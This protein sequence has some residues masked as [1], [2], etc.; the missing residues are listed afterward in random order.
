[1]AGIGVT[2]E[3]HAHM[4][5]LAFFRPLSF[6]RN[7]ARGGRRGAGDRRLGNVDLGRGAKGPSKMEGMQM[8]CTLPSTA[9]RLVSNTMSET[10]SAMKLCGGE[11]AERRA[12]L[13]GEEELEQ[14]SNACRMIV[15]IS[16]VWHG[17]R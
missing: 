4:H 13:R 8:P 14:A 10:A 11:Q 12:G 1:M 16:A 15:S 9:R 3:R 17:G 7:D 2:A 6:T 5:S